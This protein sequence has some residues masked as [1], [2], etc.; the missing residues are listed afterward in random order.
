MTCHWLL[1]LVAGLV[2]PALLLPGCKSGNSATTPDQPPRLTVVEQPGGVIGDTLLFAVD[3][4]DDLTE[5]HWA[6]GGGA[7]PNL[8]TEE[9]PVVRLTSAGE[10]DGEVQARN[11][12]GWSS[13]IPFHYRVL[14]ADEPPVV[15]GVSPIGVIGRKEDQARVHATVLG[16]VET[17]DWTWFPSSAVFNLGHMHS[18]DPV[19]SLEQEGMVT[20]RVVVHGPLGSSEPFEFTATISPQLPAEITRV[21]LT[22]GVRAHEYATLTASIAAHNHFLRDWEWNLDPSTGT[23]PFSFST[24]GPTPPGDRMGVWLGEAGVLRGSLSARA[25]ADTVTNDFRVTIAANPN[26]PVWRNY[27]LAQ[28]GGQSMPSLLVQGGEID[29]SFIDTITGDVQVARSR[30]PVP[31]SSSDWQIH[32]VDTLIFG[33]YHGGAAEYLNTALVQLGSHLALTYARPNPGPGSGIVARFALSADLS[34]TDPSDWTI[35]DLPP[36]SAGEYVIYRP[37][38]LTWQGRPVI[39]S[40][41]QLFV[42]D[43][44]LP[45]EAAN[46]SYVERPALDRFQTAQAIYRLY[47][48]VEAGGQ[49]LMPYLVY[50]YWRNHVE[51]VLIVASPGPNFPQDPGWS[52]YDLFASGIRFDD[53]GRTIAS[54]FHDGKP[55]IFAKMD[56]ITCLSAKTAAPTSAADWDVQPVGPPTTRVFGLSCAL[57]GTTAVISGFHHTD[58]DSN[59]PLVLRG[60]PFGPADSGVRW[61]REF[62]NTISGPDDATRNNPKTQICFAGGRVLMVYSDESTSELRIALADAPWGP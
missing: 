46:W 45:V 26:R 41:G 6:F 7:T 28:A 60:V 17:A 4:D 19:L 42:A 1:R 25:E 37:Q 31:A 56:Q 32:H 57:S 24:P 50:G 3:T 13:R 16:A 29:L 59:T 40:L 49:L 58:S 52:Q 5:I 23:L 34:P 12:A 2:F 44:A 30:V 43:S 54:V 20:G 51:S 15:V 18:L 55:V 14:A 27:S 11:A 47:A 22:P 35:H 33:N 8:S 21:S 61:Q 39:E 38:L 36:D 9:S 53:L 10:F 48:P 62:L